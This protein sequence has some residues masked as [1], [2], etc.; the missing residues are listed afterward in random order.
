MSGANA[1]IVDEVGT[2]SIDAEEMGIM[3]EENVPPKV[4]LGRCESGTLRTVDDLGSL[5]DVSGGELGAHL[6][7]HVGEY[8]ND[9]KNN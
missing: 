7:R 3:P 4:D 8:G 5:A 6:V 1:S 2:A 9:D